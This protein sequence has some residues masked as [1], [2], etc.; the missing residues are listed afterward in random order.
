MGCNQGL[1][2]LSTIDGRPLVLDYLNTDL[3]ATRTPWFICFA[4]GV[5]SAPS[6]VKRF[7]M[8]ILAATRMFAEMVLAKFW[9]ASKAEPAKF[10]N[11]CF[12][13]HGVIKGSR[14][15]TRMI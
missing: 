13:V 5:S 15:S 4:K 3:R 6:V 2:S 7:S 9:T 12:R 10:G 11:D 1:T 8:D 14:P